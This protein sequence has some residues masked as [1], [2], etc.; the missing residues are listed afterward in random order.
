LLGG[1]AF[2]SSPC[3]GPIGTI[4]SNVRSLYRCPR[5]TKAPENASADYP[6]IASAKSRADFAHYISDDFFNALKVVDA[7]GLE[8]GA[9]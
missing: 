1:T 4:V 6:V 7:P 9:R 5:R 3:G 8:P 2:A